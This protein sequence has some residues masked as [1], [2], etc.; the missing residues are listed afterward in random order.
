MAT[1][2]A[3]RKRKDSA[4]S[5][6]QPLQLDVWSR[7]GQTKSGRRRRIETETGGHV[8]LGAIT[9]TMTIGRGSQSGWT[10]CPLCGTY[11][12]KKYAIGRGL[13]DHLAAIH[14][15]WRPTKMAQKIHRRQFE[16]EERQKRM[17]TG[18]RQPAPSNDYSFQLLTE[19]EPTEDDRTDWNQKMLGI[20]RAVEAEAAKPGVGVSSDISGGQSASFVGEGATAPSYRESLPP[21]LCAAAEG[22]LTSLQSLVVIAKQDDNKR[23]AKENN[24]NQSGVSLEQLL[25]TKDRH[26]STAEHW[27]AGGGH[28]ECLIYLCKLRKSSTIETPTRAT[29]ARTARIRIRRRDGK[30]PLHYAARNGH[31][32]CIR[33]LLRDRDCAAT[34]DGGVDVD[35]RSGEGTTP[36]HLACYGGH[37]AAVRHLVEEEGADPYAL[38]DWECS[39]AHWVAMTINENEQKVRRLCNYLRFLEQTPDGK[40]VEGDSTSSKAITASGGISFVATQCQ[41]HT[42]LHKAAHRHNKHVIRWLADDEKNGGAGLSDQEK[43]QAGQPDKGGHRPSDIWRN[44]GGD[45]V[46]AEWMEKSMGW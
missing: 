37:L 21:F 14:T 22:D 42:A 2:A 3:G 45:P 28:L 24:G 15:P 9:T 29:T 43:M 30:T 19:W 6:G 26:K 33:Y 17:A 31:V 44:T 11:G 1:M 25:D 8:F 13:A 27:A 46:F 38:N 39:C 7:V 32:E 34:L 10:L 40:G 23:K 5:P 41:G 36:L 35:E 12:Q 18:G 20:L 4:P 16:L